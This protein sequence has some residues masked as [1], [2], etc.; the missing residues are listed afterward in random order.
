MT[1][2]AGSRSLLAENT[3]GTRMKSGAVRSFELRARRLSAPSYLKLLEVAHSG[4]AL[5][6]CPAII[7]SCLSRGRVVAVV[8]ARPGPS[9]SEGALRGKSDCLPHDSSR[10]TL[11]FLSRS[12]AERC[13][14]DPALAWIAVVVADV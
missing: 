4:G 9:Q 3:A 1:S 7:A 13:A 5:D 10:R 2:M 6:W 12:R 8:H 14:G 11:D